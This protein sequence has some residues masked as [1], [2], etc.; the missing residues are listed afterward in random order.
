MELATWMLT[1]EIWF[2]RKGSPD[3]KSERLGDYAFTLGDGVLSGSG[4]GG[5]NASIVMSI[6]DKYKRVE[7][8]SYLT[9]VNTTSSEDAVWQ[10]EEISLTGT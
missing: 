10:P 3:V 8:E 2:R 5:P 6:L 4:E 1:S 7:A 9:P